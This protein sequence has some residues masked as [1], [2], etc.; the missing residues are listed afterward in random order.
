VVLHLGEPP[1][2]KV[3]GQW[4]QSS[5]AS[6]LQV[7]S[8][9]VVI[10]PLQMMSHTV[11]GSIGEVLAPLVDTVGRPSRGAFGAASGTP[12]WSR[13]HHAEERAQQ[14]ISDVL[15]EMPTLTEPSVARILTASEGPLVVSSSM[16]I[17][18]V[19]W[20]GLADQRASVLANRGANGIDG[21]I[22]TG[23]GV[24]AG[25]GRVTRVLLGDVAFVHDS[26]S[27]AALQRRDV[28]VKMVVID[29][30][31][32]GIFSFLPQAAELGDATFER[33]FGTPHGTDVL[34]LARA[35]HVRA[36]QAGTAGELRDALALP[37]NCVVRVPSGRAANVQVHQ[38]L[39][40]AVAGALG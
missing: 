9:D 25:S 37:G 20:F 40:A 31:G 12:W 22:A 24:S 26:S 8:R 35:H 3:L 38:E 15:G 18:D 6:H 34:A 36:H 17:R 2:S 32:G 11:I 27:L 4:L 28:E 5:G 30:D 16:P 19:E 23:I 7:L 13:W 29:N 1:A 39:H 33:L 21:I 14:A 10:D